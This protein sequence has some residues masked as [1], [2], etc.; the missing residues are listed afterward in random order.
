[1]TVNTVTEMLATAKECV[2]RRQEETR[3][4]GKKK[5]GGEERG[6]SLLGSSPDN[7]LLALSHICAEAA[8]AVL[9]G[10]QASSFE[11]SD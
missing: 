5:E 3:A 10:R 2:P 4:E 6:A 8:S 9:A 1:M 7:K 11:G